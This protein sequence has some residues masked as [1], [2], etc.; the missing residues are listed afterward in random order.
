MAPHTREP[1]TSGAA[2][3]APTNGQG[4]VGI[5]AGRRFTGPDPHHMPLEYRFGKG[6]SARQ[7]PVC[8]A[9]AADK[10]DGLPCIPFLRRAPALELPPDQPE[11]G[12]GLAGPGLTPHRDGTGLT[13]GPP[14]AG[15]PGR[16]GMEPAA[17][18]VTAGSLWGFSARG[19]H[20]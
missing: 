12:L 7:P 2:P 5:A 13:G 6:P 15:Q 3:T 8:V 19:A 16:L 14:V 1:A 18:E 9:I 11:Q 20:P 17:L 4:Q 10:S